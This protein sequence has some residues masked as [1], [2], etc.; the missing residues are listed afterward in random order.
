MSK[1]YDKWA[2]ELC[3]YQTCP[4][5]NG[6]SCNNGYCYYAVLHL[7]GKSNTMYFT[8]GKPKGE[9]ISEV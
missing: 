2:Q 7:D 8:C 5:Q 9:K 4:R 1:S 6:E 3:A